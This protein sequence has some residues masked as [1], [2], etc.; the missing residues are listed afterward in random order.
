DHGSSLSPPIHALV[1]ARLGDRPLADRYFH[2]T[3]EID[4]AN[5]MGNA[6]G[7]VHVAALGGLWQA[8]VFGYA[9][10]RLEQN[11]PVF[12]PRL[13]DSW[14]GLRLAI[15]YRGRQFDV[16]LPGNRAVEAQPPAEASP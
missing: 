1:A 4:L 8:A 13:P 2:Q 12:D 16:S 7:G 10:L 11:G 14:R 15:Q 9:G 3:A 5:N 6:A